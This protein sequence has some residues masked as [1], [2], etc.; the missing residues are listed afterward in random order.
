MPTLNDIRILS[1]IMTGDMHGL[2]GNTDRI[3]ATLAGFDKT[4][5]TVADRQ[6]TLNLVLFTT[7]HWITGAS[8]CGCCGAM[9]ARGL[10]SISSLFSGGFW[11]VPMLNSLQATVHA[12]R[13]TWDT[14]PATVDAVATFLR[15]AA[16]SFAQHPSIDVT[17]V[18][19]PG[20]DQLVGDMENLLRAL[21]AMK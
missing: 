18:Q 13:G 8:P 9:S 12:G 11:M 5:A 15:T 6:P 16:V 3:D 20:G 10:P 1:T 2:S 21:G 17:S 7:R 4:A 19:S 14:A